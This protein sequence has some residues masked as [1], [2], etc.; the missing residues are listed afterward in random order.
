[1]FSDNEAVVAE[2]VLDGDAVLVL[3]AV[4]MMPSLHSVSIVQRAEISQAAVGLPENKQIRLLDESFNIKQIF[5][6]Y[7]L[8]NYVE[9]RGRSSQKKD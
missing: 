7:R 9:M 1:M 4:A 6:N 5:K 3:A 8:E 2:G